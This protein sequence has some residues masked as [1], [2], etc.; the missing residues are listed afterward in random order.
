MLRC[1][2][3]AAQPAPAV[4]PVPLPAAALEGVRQKPF[5]P[6]RTIYYFRY[7]DF[8][9]KKTTSSFVFARIG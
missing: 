5:Y 1:E 4:G 7:M 9:G 3:I 8:V 6:L 2:A